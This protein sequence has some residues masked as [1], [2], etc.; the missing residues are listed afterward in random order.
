MLRQDD[1]HLCLPDKDLLLTRRITRGALS[2]F[3]VFCLAASPLS[4]GPA[5]A[6][7]TKTLELL[8][9][10]DFHGRISSDIGMGL[11]K[12][13]QDQRAQSSDSLFLSAGDNISASLFVSSVQ[14]DTPTLDYLNA[15]G[16]QA[17]AVGNHEFDR[18]L[19]DLQTRVQDR[20]NFP[21]LAANVIDRASGQ[22]AME[23][24]TI[25]ETKQGISVA[26]IGTV[27]QDTP[28]MIN[29]AL[30]ASVDFIDPVQ[31]TNTYARKLSDGDRANGEAD[32]IIAEYHEGVDASH[33]DSDPIVSGTDP[34]VDVIFTGHTHQEYL[35]DTPL[36]G[37]PGKTRPVL[38]TGNYGDNLGVVTLTLDQH[39]ELLSYSS[40]LR[41]RAAQPSPAEVAADPL[42]QRTQEILTAAEDY[43][44]EQ[45]SQEV[46]SLKGKITT[47]WDESQINNR[48]GFDQRDLEST[49]G[50]LLADMYLWAANSTGRTS[51]DIGIVNPGG[52]RDEFPS[53][54]RSSLQ[55]ATTS[56][57]VSDVI[58]VAPFANNLWTTDLTGAQLKQVLEEQWQQ[59]ANGL[60]ATRPYL[61]LGL[62]ENVSYTYRGETGAAGYDER[63]QHIQQIFVNGKLVQDSDVF[64]VALPSFL[65]GGGDNFRTLAEGKNN[66]DTA[67]VDSEAFIAYLKNMGEV[68]AR[69]G[70]QAVRAEQVSSSYSLG[71]MLNFLLTDLQTRSFEVPDLTSL[72]VSVAGIRLGQVELDQGVAV[73]NLPLSGKGIPA[74]EQEILLTDTSGKTGTVVRLK[75]RFLASSAGA[76]P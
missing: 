30:V 6:Q 71:G 59:D 12:T 26:V 45:G 5:F 23:P 42:L 66:Q 51:A 67:L 41:P 48:G 9:I 72:E 56:L 49:M 10:N 54:L 16:L 43:A 13:I 7:Q 36:P 2:C 25:L 22:P 76:A 52:L 74:G 68:S 20:A 32:L 14:E 21:Y 8:N 57:K 75:A 70:K 28:S 44:Q 62:S 61:Q 47:G 19:R 1:K 64:R 31:A 15:L 73:V 58:S 69:Y 40:S 46:A 33:P 17:S 18:G 39:N 4:W 38:Q 29:P 65:L 37:Q 60:P 55:T 34:A 24:Y 27:S 11:A 50:H 35:L 63:G 53:G 3:L